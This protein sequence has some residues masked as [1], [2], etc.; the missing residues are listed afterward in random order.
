MSRRKYPVHN[1][2][3]KKITIKHIAKIANVNPST[4][5]R[6]LNGMGSKKTID[7]IKKIASELNYFPDTLAKSLRVKKTNTVGI[8]FNDL[9]NPFYTEVLSSI[10]TYLRNKNYHMIVTYSEYDNKKEKNNIIS[11]LSKRVDGI[12][13]SPIDDYSENI[14]YLINNNIHNYT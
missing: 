13:V 7:K 12:I 5:S 10:G 4:V 3:D 1:N 8:I 6:A 9:N 2:V 11:L 14:Q